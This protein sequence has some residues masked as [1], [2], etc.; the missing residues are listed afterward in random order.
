MANPSVPVPEH[1]LIIGA[2]VFGLATTLSLLSRSA[3]KSTRITIVD[4][5][6]S[7]PNPSGS[8]VDASRI[9]RGDYAQQHYSRLALEAQEFW[10]DR[11]KEAWGGE[12]RY[13]E[14]GFVLS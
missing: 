8:S 12:G 4:G 11:R 6:S 5:S 14:P 7:L 9:I 1:I 13:H 10:R 3:Y 2:G